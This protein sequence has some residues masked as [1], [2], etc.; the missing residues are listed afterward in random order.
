MNMLYVCVVL[1]SM[2][3]CLYVKLVHVTV[4]VG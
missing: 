4:T 1:V 2:A 3:Y